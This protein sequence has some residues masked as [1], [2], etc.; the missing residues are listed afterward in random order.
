M[1]RSSLVSTKLEKYIEQHGEPRNEWELKTIIRLMKMKK[2]DI[3]SEYMFEKF[4]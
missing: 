1:S 2:I 3:I 4:G